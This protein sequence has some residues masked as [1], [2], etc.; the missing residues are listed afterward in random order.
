MLEWAFSE[1][2]LDGEIRRQIQRVRLA[3]GIRRTALT[4]ALAHSLAQDLHYQGGDGA[5]AL[6]LQG[7]G[8][9]AEPGRFAIWVRSCAVKGI[10]LRRGSYYDFGGQ[11]RA[12]TRLGFTAYTPEE[13]QRA[14]AVMA[15]KGP[16]PAQGP[17]AR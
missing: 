11:E 8:A 10:K 7:K 3:A 12:A 2:L 16:V 15:S 9:L 17:A 6:W 5:S 13:L 1:L 14:V 4:D